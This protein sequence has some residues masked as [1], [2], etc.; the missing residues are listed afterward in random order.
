VTTDFGT[1]GINSKIFGLTYLIKELSECFQ[2]APVSLVFR[3]WWDKGPHH[4]KS[5]QPPEEVR[6]YPIINGLASTIHLAVC[7]THEFELIID[8]SSTSF[9]AEL[10]DQHSNNSMVLALLHRKPD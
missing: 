2:R 5:Y 8:E 10:S 9:Y 1:P 7:R 6:N 3:A 4:A